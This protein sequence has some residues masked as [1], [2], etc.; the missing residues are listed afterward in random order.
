MEEEQGEEKKVS[1]STPSIG[2]VYSIIQENVSGIEDEE[3]EDMALEDIQSLVQHDN[4]LSD[5]EDDDDWFWW[6]AQGYAGWRF[7]LCRL[8][9]RL[10]KGKGEKNKKKIAS[11][12][13][14]ID[15][16]LKENWN[17]SKI[18]AFLKE[19]DDTESVE[20]EAKT[21]KNIAEFLNPEQEIY[22]FFQD[23][24]NEEDIEASEVIVKK[25]PVSSI[26][27]EKLQSVESS[28]THNLNE[29]YV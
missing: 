3:D 1:V 25:Q 21:D 7:W 17:E 8:D 4:D 28:I 12:G 23:I 13:G 15:G 20:A 2:Q 19:S 10:E 6:Q 9:L 18:Y 5:D 27:L 14:K 22:D 24:E 26:E 11:K 29:G 16:S